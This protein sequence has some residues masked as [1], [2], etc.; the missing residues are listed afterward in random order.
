[1]NPRHFES[2]EEDLGDEMCGE[3]FPE[4]PS[5]DSHKDVDE[6]V[7]NDRISD[8]E[9]HSTETRPVA[10]LST[11]V[12]DGSSDLADDRLRPHNHDFLLEKL[13]GLVSIIDEI[14][15]NENIRLRGFNDCEGSN[16]FEVA[17]FNLDFI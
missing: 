9:G 1:M 5:H 7:S 3:A 4:S 17:V 11:E 14:D 6:D 8:E 16:N 12:L 10:S 13:F 15:L 2:A